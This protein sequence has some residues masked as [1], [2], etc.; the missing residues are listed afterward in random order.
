[1]F[2][3]LMTWKGRFHFGKDWAAYRGAAADNALHA[4][5]AV[6]LCFSLNQ[7]VTLTDQSGHA[8]HG[9]ALYVRSCIRHQ[10][11]PIDSLQIILVE[12]YSAFGRALLTLLPSDGIG[13]CPKDVASMVDLS[14]PL[15]Q[16][17]RLKD[18]NAREDNEALDPRLAK[19]LDRLMSATHAPPLAELARD[20]GLSPSR[21]RHLA[22][23]EL[24]L[25]LSKY[26]LWRKLGLAS[27]ALARGESLAQ[28]AAAGG[29]ADQAHFTKSMRALVGLTP[30]EARGPLS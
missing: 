2:V 19:S 6:Q 9:S 27:R 7:P 13:P 3:F 4:H 24:G 16:C 5:V 17:L 21:L 12:P 22:Y 30:G 8:V 20:V 14:A 11:A 28:A 1:M 10:L 26:V 23:T 25:P 18:Q 29:F 15:D